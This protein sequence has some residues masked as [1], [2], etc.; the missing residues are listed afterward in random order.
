MSK[1]LIGK[2]IGWLAVA[3]AIIGIL[4][5]MTVLGIVA[6]VLGIIGYF[7][8]AGVNRISLTAA[9]MGIVALLLGNIS[10]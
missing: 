9:A 8:K 5:Q 6:I 2:I 1:S 4:Y 10:Y 3:A 7:L